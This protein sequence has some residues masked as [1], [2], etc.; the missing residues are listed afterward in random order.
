ML[1]LHTHCGFLAALVWAANCQET[2]DFIIAGAGTCGSVVA[3]RLSSD[4]NLSVLVIE[5]GLDERANPNVTSVLGFLSAFNTPIDWAYNITPQASLG[6]RG[7]QYHAGKAWGGT[8]TINGMTFLRGDRAEIDAWE[9]LGNKGWNWDSLWPHYK[10]VERFEVPTPAQTD[11][12][13]SWN[14]DFHGLDGELAT[15]YAYELINGSLHETWRQTWEGLGFPW[16]EDANGG[17][18][19]GISIWP[20]TLDRDADTR[21]DASRA[22]IQPVESRPNLKIIQGTVKRLTWNEDGDVC[23]ATGVEYLTAA[24]ETITIQAHKEVILSAGALRSPL[25]LE[26]SGIGQPE[27]LQKLGIETKIDLPGVGENMIEQPLG[28]V[29]YAGNVPNATGTIVPFGLFI[30]ARDTFGEQTAAVAASTKANLS[31][32]AADI[33]AANGGIISAEALLEV[34]E[35]QHDLIF[36][37]NV[38]IGE[39]LSNF[40]EQDGYRYVANVWWPLLPFSR[41]SVHLKSANAID[42]PAIDPQYLLADFDVTVMTG[43]G[44]VAQSFF[45]QE[46]MSNNITT[47]LLPGDALLPRNATD[48]QWRNVLVDQVTPN[49]HALASA[50]MMSREL[51]GVVD[52]ELRVYGTR[53]VRVVDASVVPLQISGHLTAT[54]YALADRA[55]AIIIGEI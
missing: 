22:F 28:V 26:S 13:A 23:E 50:A 55:A 53:N 6:G 37:H 12:G 20:S 46:P 16:N 9:S 44:R 30:N 21:E 18:I 10:G 5:P 47:A 33:S 4:P 45:F 40:A 17:D 8:S 35:I 11:A 54:L 24:G 3:N 49:H 7:M 14:P 42:D 1:R 27:R 51:G 43:V 2:Y 41:G 39:I 19:R 25:I 32:W 31:S 38:T 34:F 48:E 15:G 29:A 52:S 36:N